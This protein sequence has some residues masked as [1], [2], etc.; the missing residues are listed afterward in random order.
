MSVYVIMY[1]AQPRL[2][3]AGMGKG[4]KEMGERVKG[5][6]EARRNRIPA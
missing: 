2:Q 4:K 5:K 1:E 6:K 3:G